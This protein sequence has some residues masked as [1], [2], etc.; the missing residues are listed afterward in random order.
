MDFDASG[1]SKKAREIFGVCLD[2]VS[3][4]FVLHLDGIGCFLGL[5]LPVELFPLWWPLGLRVTTSCKFCLRSCEYLTMMC[6][7]L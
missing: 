2:S 6:R 7:R 5:A 4:L 1:S 3:E